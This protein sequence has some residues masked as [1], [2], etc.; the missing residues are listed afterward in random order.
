MHNVKVRL[1]VKI[2]EIMEQCFILLCYPKG[3][4]EDNRTKGTS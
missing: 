4:I 3:T 1:M 2:E